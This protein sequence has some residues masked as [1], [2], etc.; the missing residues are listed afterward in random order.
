MLCSGL[1]PNWNS[2]L[3]SPLREALDG[4]IPKELPARM[5]EETERRDQGEGE[6]PPGSSSVT[7]MVKP[8]M[9]SLVTQSNYPSFVGFETAL[10]LSP[11]PARL[12]LAYV[13]V[14][15][16]WATTPLG[17][18]WSGAEAGFLFGVMARMVLGALVAVPLLWMLGLRMVYTPQALWAYAAGSLAIFGGMLT[19]YWAAQYLPSGMISVLFGTAPIFTSLLAAWWLGERQGWQGVAGM[20]VAFGGLALIFL[21]RLTLDGVGGLAVLAMLVS[22]LLHAASTVLVKRLAAP[23]PGAVI[24]VGALWLSALLYLALWWIVDGHWPEQAGLR[25]WASI[26]YLAVFGSVFGF[27]LFFYALQHLPASLMGMMTL[28]APVLALWL[29]WVVQDERLPP[30][31]LLGS[32]LVLGGLLLAQ[33]RDIELG[34]IGSWFRGLRR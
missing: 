6:T 13:A 21:D 4:R 27:M 12:M 2:S 34:R 1:A 25:T 5:P 31:A 18:Q 19:T 32:A 11:S 14:V 22:A 9:S 17:I 26:A 15:L 3:P 16:I 23:V 24:S 29:G 30:Q 28:L 7:L 20:L 8:R 33:G 10:S